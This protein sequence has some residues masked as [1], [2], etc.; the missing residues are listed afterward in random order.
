MNDDDDDEGEDSGSS[1]E[2]EDED[3]EGLDAKMEL[4]ILN[5]INSLRKKDPRIYDT[6]ATWFKSEAEEEEGE[7]EEVVSHADK[8]AREV[9]TRRE[10]KKTYSTVLR[11]HLLAHG[12]GGEEEEELNAVQRG[13]AKRNSN[14]A[15][16]AEQKVTASPKSMQNVIDFG[17]IFACHLLI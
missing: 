17:Y 1:S 16:D 15:Y 8:S 7:E 4:Q 6:E 13:R 5:T 9:G 11:E 2:S 14:L 10:K 3:G 12:A